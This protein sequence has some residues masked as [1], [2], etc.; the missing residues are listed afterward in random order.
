[1]A[2][3]ARFWHA[4]SPRLPPVFVRSKISA[5]LISCKPR[6]GENSH[7]RPLTYKMVTIVTGRIFSGGDERHRDRSIAH[8]VT[9][10][11]KP[12]L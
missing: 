3:N 10:V 2:H 1:V 11:T 9:L 4:P 5:E 8:G 12:E 7:G 6:D